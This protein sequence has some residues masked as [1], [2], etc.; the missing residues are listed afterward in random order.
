MFSKFIYGDRASSVFT[1]G[2]HPINVAINVSKKILY[3]VNDTSDTV[4]FFNAVTGG[5]YFS[6]DYI[7]STFISGG[8]S[9]GLEFNRNNNIL[10]VTV[11]TVSDDYVTF[12]M[13]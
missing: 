5:Y 7:D 13:L 1:T 8:N 9:I 12:L 6:N 4:T 11:S 3:V 2:D 10:Y